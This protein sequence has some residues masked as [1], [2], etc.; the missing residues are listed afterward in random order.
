MWTYVALQDSKE[1]EGRHTYS[2]DDYLSS[3]DPCD[4][5]YQSTRD[6][7]IISGHIFSDVAFLVMIVAVITIVVA[8]QDLCK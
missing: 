2:R 6:A 5:V 3:L 7:L 4:S 8:A 1:V